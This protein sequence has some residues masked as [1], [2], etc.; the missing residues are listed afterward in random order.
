MRMAWMQKNVCDFTVCFWQL[1]WPG[2]AI[3][4]NYEHHTRSNDH[5]KIGI[6]GLL[7]W[8]EDEG[9]PDAVVLSRRQPVQVPA[10]REYSMIYR[11][12]DL[13]AVVYDLAPSPPPLPSASLLSLLTGMGGGG[14]EGGTKAYNGEK[15]WSSINH[16]I[17]SA[18]NRRIRTPQQSWVPSPHRPTQ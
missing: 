7:G 2:S 16:S 18:C 12:P 17:L 10:T 14:G 8:V 5:L 3:N 6:V 4:S 15:A 1:L 9:L 13:L 11:R